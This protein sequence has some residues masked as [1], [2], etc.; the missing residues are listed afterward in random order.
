MGLSGSTDLQV[1]VQ[2][3]VAVTGQYQLTSVNFGSRPG[4]QVVMVQDHV[5]VT[6]VFTL[7]D[8]VED[9]ITPR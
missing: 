5:P 8:L 4:V 6:D 3:D 9:S 7:W 1:H 2:V